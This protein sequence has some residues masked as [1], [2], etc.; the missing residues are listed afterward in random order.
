MTSKLNTFLFCFLFIFL[1]ACSEDDDIITD[2]N[3]ET[4][5]PENPEETPE[6]GEDNAEVLNPNFTWSIMSVT[7]IFTMLQKILTIQKM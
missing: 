1:A 7:I 4:E 5:T 6:E 2:P 3:E